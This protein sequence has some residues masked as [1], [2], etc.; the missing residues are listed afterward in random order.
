MRVPWVE[1]LGGDAALLIELVGSVLIAGYCVA[2]MVA[3]ARGRG[4]R[5]AQFLVAEG[6]LTGLSFKLCATLLKTMLLV[7][8]SQVGIFACVLALRTILKRVFVAERSGESIRWRE[9]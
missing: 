9:N 6:A 2:A 3:L 5:A 7:S 8:W 4:R 1:G